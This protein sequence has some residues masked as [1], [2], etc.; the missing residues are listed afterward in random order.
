MKRQKA[1][2]LPSFADKDNSSSEQD[3]ITTP[4]IVT[5]DTSDVSIYTIQLG[6]ASVNPTHQSAQTRHHMPVA[7]AT[8]IPRLSFNFQRPHRTD[9]EL[10]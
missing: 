4:L 10:N 3:Y 7:A 8:T 9:F 2:V 1:K 5:Y 6:R